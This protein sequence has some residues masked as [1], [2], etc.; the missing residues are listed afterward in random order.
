MKN[1]IKSINKLIVDFSLKI[2]L[3]LIL[4]TFLITFLME[5][6]FL[7]KNS[8]NP[9]SSNNYYRSSTTLIEFHTYCLLS[10]IV[11]LSI[12]V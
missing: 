9:D 8:Q 11:W 6:N 10:I 12:I 5:S 4:I 3:H 7:V 1:F 2:L